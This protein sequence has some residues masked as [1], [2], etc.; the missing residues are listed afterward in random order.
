MSTNDAYAEMA[1]NATPKERRGEFLS[2][3]VDVYTTKKDF[4]AA[5]KD[6]M[7]LDNNSRAFVPYRIGGRRYSGMPRMGKIAGSFYSSEHDLYYNYSKIEPRLRADNMDKN[8]KNPDRYYPPE[9]IND[10]KSRRIT[11]EYL[12]QIQH[13]ITLTPEDKAKKMSEIR[14]AFSDW[15]KFTSSVRGFMTDTYWTSLFKLVPITNDDIKNIMR[16]AEASK[17]GINE[18]YLKNWR[19]WLYSS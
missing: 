19:N 8:K 16:T 9:N 15:S 7:R 12:R 17:Y 2:K 1:A 6:L 11:P 10:P 5:Y 13:D 4:L 18:Q 14:K 3:A